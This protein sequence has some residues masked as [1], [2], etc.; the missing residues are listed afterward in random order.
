M[1]Q[2]EEHVRL[3]AMFHYIFAGIV[4]LFACFPVFHLAFGLVLALKPEM[5]GPMKDQPPAFIG[6]LFVI[7]AS[8]FI[9]AGWT[10]AAVVAWAGRCLQKRR[11]HLFCLIMAGVACMCVPFGTVLGVFTIIVLVRPS[12]KELFRIPAMGG[13]T[14]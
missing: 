9:L 6:W 1:S 10:F 4:A 5:F 12:V 11:H 3:L 8:F 7:F 14:A 13:Q 2:D